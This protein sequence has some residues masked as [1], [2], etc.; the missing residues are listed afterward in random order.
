MILDTVSA[1]Q[2]VATPN[3]KYEGSAG[4]SDQFGDEVE[5]IWCLLRQSLERPLDLELLPPDSVDKPRLL[6]VVRS[7]G[8]LNGTSLSRLTLFTSG[9]TGKPK[10]VTHDI[11]AA[12][13]RKKEGNRGERWLLTFS[14]FRWAG[15]SV[16][17]H[18]LKARACLIVPNSLNPA[19]LVRTAV[20][21]EANHI[22]L[23]PSLFRQIQLSV[24]FTELSRI[25]LR[26]VT[27]GGE[28][29]T[30]PIL[31]AA[32]SLWPLAR[33]THLYAAT[34]LGDICAISDGLEGIP[35][36]K[37]KASRFTF[38]DAGELSVDD[39]PTGD[40]WQLRQGRYHFFGRREEIINVGGAKISPWDVEAAAMRVEGVV[41]VRAYSVP[42][43][44]LGQVVALDYLGT[45]S[46]FQLRRSLASMLPKVAWPAQINLVETIKINASGKMNRVT[47]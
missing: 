27:F 30:Q 41:Q 31:D 22:S 40:F 19:K 5:A 14:P 39:R 17:L 33:V 2:F 10:P 4:G 44:L 29:A 9:T 42:S 26:Q 24:S 3:C 36:V 47:G 38:S 45:C 35:E 32:R 13:E 25:P 7:G 1:C 11:R 23:T 21:C 6:D 8:Q 37:L 20:E 46:T 15:V 43:P 34:E 28:A 12:Y 18:V 16:L